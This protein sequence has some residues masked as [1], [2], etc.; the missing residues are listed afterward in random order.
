MALTPPK[1]EFLDRFQ[2]WSVTELARAIE[3]V[4]PHSLAQIVAT[5][6]AQGPPCEPLQ[7]EVLV[8]WGNP[9]KENAP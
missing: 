2:W 7:V 3:R 5:Y 4:T 8:D 9:E 1:P 6:I